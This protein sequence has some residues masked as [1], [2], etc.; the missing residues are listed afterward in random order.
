[1]SENF[2]LK[3]NFCYMK[4]CCDMEISEQSYVVCQNGISQGVFKELPEKYR[5]FN[6]IDYGDQIIIPGLTDLHI[7]APQFSFRGLN[8]D[9]ELLD[10]LNN[11]TFPEEAKYAD[12]EYAKRAYQIFAES[13]R[14]SATTRACV[15]ATIHTDAT[16]ELMDLM[17]HTGLKTYIGKVNMDRNSPEELIEPSAAESAAATVKWLRETA[18]QY[19]NVKPILTPRFIPSCS[20]GL[21]E[22]LS[23]IQKEYQLPVQSHLS[24]NPGEVEWVKELSP[25]S[26]CY[27][28]AY[29]RFGLFGSNG[30]TIMAHCVYSGQQEQQRMLER[31]VYVAHCPG[32]N[33]N[34]SSGIAP[35]KE[36]LEK[37]IHVGLGSDVGGGF[38]HS[39]FRVMVEAI[40][41]SKMRWRLLD[42][43]RKPLTINEVFYLATRGG[44]EFFGQVGSFEKGYEFDA[45]VLS[46][47]NLKT[48]RVLT[49]RERLERLIYLSDDQCIKAKFVAGKRVFLSEC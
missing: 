29:D 17:E 7:H 35:V 32:S 19:H 44:G 11:T 6:L 1:M 34:L 20:D 13:M 2:V 4:D 23:D 42:Q 36:F 22:Q 10:W 37:G 28:D 46:D 45:V 47:W 48:A 43:E 33:L 16:K 39:I 21:M 31:G 40:Q 41:S 49:V 24:E 14:S 12:Q 15:F 30:K 8:M 26:E 18:G 3:G 5:H 25:D 27:G 9:M 38:T